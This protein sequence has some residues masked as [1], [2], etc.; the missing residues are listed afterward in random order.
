MRTESFSTM[1]I[2]QYFKIYHGTNKIWCIHT[3]RYPN[4]IYFIFL[5]I[6]TSQK[7]VLGYYSV[8]FS[9]QICSQNMLQ[10]IHTHLWTFSI[11]FLRSHNV[12]TKI[13]NHCYDTPDE[14]GAFKC[15]FVSCTLTSI[16]QDISSENEAANF[17]TGC[18]RLEQY[19]SITIIQRIPF[20]WTR[21]EDHTNKIWYSPFLLSD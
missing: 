9:S 16:K 7:N 11:A 20:N 3:Q 2:L 15:N 18:L 10:S 21:A 6:R 4:F 17:D 5:Q 12:N 19:H 14:K 1:V 13:W 8:M